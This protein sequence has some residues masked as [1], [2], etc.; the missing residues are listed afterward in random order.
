MPGEVKLAKIAEAWLRGASIVPAHRI[1]DLLVTAVQAACR[2][3]LILASSHS[4]AILGRERPIV[5]DGSR[6]LPLTPRER[7]ILLHIGHGHAMKQ[8]AHLL[9]ISV[10]TVENLQSNLFRKLRVHDRT[11]ALST[12]YDLGLLDE[13]SEGD[14]NLPVTT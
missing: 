4:R 12:A 6:P 8:T 7:E 5:H 2:D 10:R 14:R 11:S 9:G 13:L 1:D 3:H